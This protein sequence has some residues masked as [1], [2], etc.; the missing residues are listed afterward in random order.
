MRGW[1]EDKPGW[2]GEDEFKVR[3]EMGKEEELAEILGERYFLNT[4]RIKLISRIDPVSAEAN[5][6]WV[7]SR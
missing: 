3:W 5:T 1:S 4:F 6:Y 2:K 7:G